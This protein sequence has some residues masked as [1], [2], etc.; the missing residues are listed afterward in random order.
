MTF[1]SLADLDSALTSPF[2]LEDAAGAHPAFLVANVAP[3]AR[4][5]HAQRFA[6]ALRSVR[7]VTVGLVSSPLDLP[8]A[9][10]A[11]HF[12]ILLAPP[13]IAGD[14]L[15]E[16]TDFAASIDLIQS[17]TAAHPA[18]AVALVELLRL[19][20]YES[21]PQ[22]LVAESLTYSVLQSGHEF[23]AWLRGRG[24]VALPQDN[25]APV[26]TERVGTA[27]QISLNRPSRANAVTA[28]MRDHLVE[29]LRVASSDPTIEGVV[30]KGVGDHFCA[31]GDL[32]E[33]GTSPDPA[34]GHATR[35]TRSPAWWIAE[36]ATNVRVHL[37]GSC[38]GAGIELPAFA[39]TVVAA[40]NTSIHLP[41]VGMGLVPGAGGTVSISRR[42]G[43]QRTAF[44]AI[45]AERIDAYQALA[46]G[47]VD[48]IEL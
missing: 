45:T 24:P 18:A 3:Q 48:R 27:L 35:L 14:A 28:A 46:W 41:E 37:H 12:D 39:G 31:G 25:A 5:P 9:E 16:S 36:Q 17:T 32:A 30:L 38:V 7:A 20:A 6:L 42:I 29:A 1:D 19:G 33:F 10:L 4:V 23:G 15:V 47:L 44:L 26:L 8:A 40:P 22:G 2:G 13:D 11:A 43:R 21:V 34:I